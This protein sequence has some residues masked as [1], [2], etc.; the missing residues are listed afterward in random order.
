MSSSDV[1][2]YGPSGLE[3]DVFEKTMNNL[4]FSVELAD[5]PGELGRV[6]ESHPRAIT[7]IATRWSPQELADLVQIV[8]SHHHDGSPA[9]FV[10]GN[11]PRMEGLEEGV[12]FVPAAQRLRGTVHGIGDYIR[13]LS[14]STSTP[15]HA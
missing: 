11:A 15:A 2:Y 7:V 8:R 5:R 14:R 1:I 3:A 10:I 4:G 13:S 6:L 9:I 12:R